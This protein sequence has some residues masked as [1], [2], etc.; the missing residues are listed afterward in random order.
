MSTK[1]TRLSEIEFLELRYFY[2][3]W[4]L[5]FV[6]VSRTESGLDVMERTAWEVRSVPVERPGARYTVIA[7]YIETAI[8]GNVD[9]LRTFYLIIEHHADQDELRV[10]EAVDPRLVRSHEFENQTLVSMFRLR[11]PRMRELSA[12]ES[13]EIAP[14]RFQAGAAITETS[15][16]GLYDRLSA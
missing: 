12:A 2:D 8:A 14:P 16:G 10:C 5:H 11:P 13:E 9:G 7:D 1:K 15:C 6:S 3:E 4:V